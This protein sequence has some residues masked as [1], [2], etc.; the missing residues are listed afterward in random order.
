M[1]LLSTLF[2][3]LSMNPIIGKSLVLLFLLPLFAFSQNDPL[4]MRYPAISPDG[5]QIVFS[6]QGDLYKVSSEGGQAIPL[7]LHDAHDYMPVWSRDGKQ[8]AFASDR[9]GN[10][11]VFVMPATGGSPKRL[12]YHSAS[13]YPSD[14]SPDG[15]QVLFSSS[16]LDDYQNMQFPKSSMSELYQVAITGGRPKQMISLPALG[17]RYS[18]DGKSLIYTDHKGTEN[19]WRK[20]HTSSVTRDIWRYSISKGTFT[21]LTTFEGE[22]RN[23]VFGKDEKKIFYLSE[24]DGTSNIYTCSI[25]TPENAEQLTVFAKH[26]VRHLSASNDGLLCFTF[27]GEIYT[28]AANESPKRVAIALFADTRNRLVENVPIKA[29]ATEMALSPSGKEVAF[30]F[31][32]EV[33]TTSVESG[34]TKRVTNTPEQERSVS[35]SPDGKALLYASE[36]NGSWNLYQSKI[37]REEEAYFFQST[38]LEEETIL[39]SEKETFQPSYSP[40]GKEVAYLEERTELRVINLE[41][42]NTRMILAGDRN[43]SYADG[44]QYYQWSPDGK[45]F[46]VNYLPPKQWIDE[47]GLVSA[48]G[49]EEVKNLTRSGYNDGAP[50]WT[51]DGK[52]MLW[53]TDRDGMK[54]HASWGTQ[55]D[56]YAMC[57]T[58]EAWDL[59]N[60]TEEEYKL[61][62]GDDDDKKWDKDKRDKK[63]EKEEKVEPL[64]IDWEGI[65]DRKKR[66]TIHASNLA[67]AILSKDNKKLYYLARFEKGY[68][69]WETNIRT[70]ETKILAKLKA[71][72]VGGLE[73][74]KKGRHLFLLSG[75]KI[76][77]V[78]LEGGKKETIAIDGEMRLNKGAERA[79]MFDHMWRQVVKKFYRVDLHGVDW[80]FYKK[81][82][83]RFLPHINNN[84]DYSEMMSELLGELNASHTGCYFRAGEATGD[85]TASLGLYYDQSYEGD[86]LKITEVIKGSPVQHK[87]SKVKT[88]VIVEKIDGRAILAG[89]NYFELLNR[90]AGEYTLLSLYDPKTKD[91]W[92]ERIKPIG[93][94]EAYNLR[95]KRWVERCRD[96]VEKLSGG[97][98]GYVHVRG[99]NDGSFR[100]VYEEVLGQNAQKEALIVDTRFNGGGWLHDDLATFLSGK[101][102]MRFQPRGQDLGPEPQ[103]KWTKPSAVVMGEANYSD[104]HMFPY[105]YRALGVGKLIGMP[106]PGTGTAVWW[107]NQQDPSL[108]FGIPQVGSVPTGGGYLENTQLEPDI[109]VRNEPEALLKGRDQQLERAVQ[110]LTKVR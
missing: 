107:E 5:S 14:F 78:S 58:E 87:G 48:T 11:D 60:M 62:K 3:F 101:E 99:M 84:H 61:L 95:Y 13:D 25:Q 85:R 12:T 81:T 18:R 30:I 103:F 75:G 35:F 93:Q 108:V 54:N 33:F 71:S 74:D 96:Q 49:T 88:G 19:A 65:E 80:D 56:V 9:Y 2:N 52:M 68:D 94:R 102:Y 91:R 26:P 86:G 46:L 50:R 36:R 105:T 42:K 1:L 40:D 23:P 34:T 97:R 32:G 16:R 72:R 73:M 4:W 64:E 21:M 41:T 6:Y 47:V 106:V 92:D 69:L 27:D 98:V 39:A 55:D 15:T 104:A 7:T 76:M 67:G 20:H 22:N 79:Y 109:K 29:G 70:K 63:E 38:V 28:K 59:L 43:Y 51:R 8:L 45:W 83:A 57:F 10:F 24:Q 66:L 37:T 53:F 44:D 100:T 77:K 31:R 82:Y 89:E 90:K 110:E 17:A